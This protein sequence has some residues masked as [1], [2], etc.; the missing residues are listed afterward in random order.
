MVSLCHIT[1]LHHGSSVRVKHGL[2]KSNDAAATCRHRIDRADFIVRTVIGRL[3]PVH[4]VV[5]PVEQLLELGGGD[6]QT[7]L[8]K[9]STSQR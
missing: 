4:V 6:L 1:T 9:K 5:E 3:K 7:W 8:L 2:H